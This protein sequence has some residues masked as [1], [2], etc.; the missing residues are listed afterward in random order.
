[1]RAYEMSLKIDERS[2]AAWSYLNLG[3][4]YLLTSEFEKAQQAYENS[5]RIWKELEQPGL[6]IEPTAGLIQVAL[7]MDDITTAVQ[8]TDIIL[9]YLDDGRT[10]DGTEEPLRIYLACITTLEK[11]ED[12]RSSD[13]L[14]SAVHLLEAQVSMFSDEESRR[15][16]V[17][18]VP[19]RLAIQ[20]AWRTSQI[21]SDN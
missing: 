2:G 3:H 17:Q 11:I 18:N 21:D 19:W 10:L 5:I 20:Q 8:Y 15:M 4:A 14:K 9:R 7:N 1:M 12:P 6:A 13:M 16:Y